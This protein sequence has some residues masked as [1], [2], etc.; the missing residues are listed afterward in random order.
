MPASTHDPA[1]VVGLGAFTFVRDTGELRG[2]SA[3]TRLA[4][5]PAALLAL[6]VDHAGEIVSRDTIKQVL[7]PDTAV[8]FEAG[9]HQC[10]RQI[11]VALGDDAARPQ[12]VETIPRRGYRLR[13]EALAQPEP[14]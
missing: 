8:D 6:L 7:W 9:L 2:A 14:T 1:R 3:T 5:Q 4:P 11:R 12:F 13:A 10:I